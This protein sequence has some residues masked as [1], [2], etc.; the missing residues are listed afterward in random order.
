MAINFSTMVYLPAFNTF[1]RSVTVNPIASQP[2]QPS[3]AAR[4]IY[5]TDPIDVLAEDATI[6]SDARTRLDIREVE[7]TVLPIQGDQITIPEDSSGLP[8]LGTYEVIDSDANGGGETSLTLRK[9][10]TTKP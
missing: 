8:A 1:A 3:Y 10:V 9:V 2:G 5:G 6:F 4:G 7:F